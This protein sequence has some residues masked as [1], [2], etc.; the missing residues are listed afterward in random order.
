M[1]FREGLEVFLIMVVIFQFLNQTN[2]GQLKKSGFY[3]LGIGVICSAIF[4]YF[5]FEFSS[6]LGETETTAKLW[7]SGASIVALILITTFIYWMMNTGRTLVEEI[8]NQ[9]RSNLSAWGVFFIAFVITLRE[10][11]EVS[12]FSFAG[13]YDLTSVFLGI[14][15]AAVLAIGTY[16]SLFRINIKA[17]FRVTLGYLI[18]QAG[19]L[20]G[21]GIHEGLSAMANLQYISESSWLLEKAFDVSDT[22]F[23]HKEGLL[24]VPLNVLVGW[25]S[26]PEWIQLIAQVVYVVTLFSIWRRILRKNK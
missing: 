17:L 18:L 5:L 2:Y 6:R 11:A 19:Y 14:G 7:E 23:Y 26:K 8:K 16:F 25:Y 12:I 22:I 1:G 21:Y 9:V 24:G 4:G 3:G 20:L 15:I 10:G 13:E